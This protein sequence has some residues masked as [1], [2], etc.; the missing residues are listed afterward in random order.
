MQNSSA[1]NGS[2]LAQKNVACR[3]SRQRVL[4]YGC[5]RIRLVTDNMYIEFFVVVVTDV[6][7]F[8]WNLKIY[9]VV[10]IISDRA[11]STRKKSRRFFLIS[12]VL[13]NDIQNCD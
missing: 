12:A 1:R 5:T 10:R 4:F 8:T 9:P 13:K 11:H 2:F 3:L 7:T 6:G